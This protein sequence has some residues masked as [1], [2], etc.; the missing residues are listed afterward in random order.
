MVLLDINF[1]ANLLLQRN[2]TRGPQPVDTVAT[3]ASCEIYEDLEVRIR[4]EEGEMILLCP[5]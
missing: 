1:F 2:G 5:S 3:F 4:K